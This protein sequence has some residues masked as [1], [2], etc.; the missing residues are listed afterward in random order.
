M[1]QKRLQLPGPTAPQQST[2]DYFPSH[3]VPDEV[4][5]QVGEF[6]GTSPVAYAAKKVKNQQRVA[7]NG[8]GQA[9]GEE[10]LMGATGMAV[11]AGLLIVSGAFSYQAGKAMAPSKKE[12]QTWAWIGVPVGMFFGSIGLGTM[13][14]V[15]NT[16][17]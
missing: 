14:I 16:S 11:L 3:S 9:E 13:G 5:K 10:A 15:S 1:K 4:F 6:F 12:E 2:V 7:A 8:L 17:K